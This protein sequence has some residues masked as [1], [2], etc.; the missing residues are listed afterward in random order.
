MRLSG[1][2]HASSVSP[3]GDRA[4]L[5]WLVGWL[6]AHDENE[7]QESENRHNPEIVDGEQSTRER[8]AK[9]SAGGSWKY[10]HDV[11]VQMNCKNN[12]FEKGRASLA[13]NHP[14]N[15]QEAKNH[16]ASH[17]LQVSSH[18]SWR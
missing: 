11:C 14:N 10:V 3:P 12:R 2:F 6:A 18:D 5:E 4:C 7:R 1:P 8:V 17:F 13:H 15:K 16:T 9:E